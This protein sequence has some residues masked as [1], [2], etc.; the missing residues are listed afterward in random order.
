MNTD[1]KNFLI[2]LF[3]T[4]KEDIQDIKK[5]QIKTC[6]ELDTVDKNVVKLSTKLKDHLES[7]NKKELSKIQS[8]KS[9]R[10]KKA[11]T[12]SVITTCTAI[13]SVVVSLFIFAF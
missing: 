6:D 10:E 13:I 4:L 1:D 5:H 7:A 12:I 9:N 8:Q 3:D 2:K 11:L